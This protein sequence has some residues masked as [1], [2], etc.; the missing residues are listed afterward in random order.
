M[1]DN[2]IGE[3]VHEI[4]ATLEQVSGVTLPPLPPPAT[5][6]EIDNAEATLGFPLPRDLRNL[7]RATRGSKD[8]DGTAI[9]GYI[10][11]TDISYLVGTT[12]GLVEEV[13]EFQSMLEWTEGDFRGEIPQGSLICFATEP[14]EG[15]FVEATGPLA[16]RVI[17]YNMHP[18]SNYAWI[19]LGDNLERYCDWVLAAAKLGGITLA[20]SPA[21]RVSAETM[22]ADRSEDIPRLR[23]LLEPLK[24]SL[25][26]A[27]ATPGAFV[28][29]DPIIIAR[30]GFDDLF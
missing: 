30:Y 12:T 10:E 23:A 3:L 13:E 8:K 14:N 24:P 11:L 2:R 16:P 5:E 17:S 20:R 1:A 25:D 26:A 21:G 22:Q 7:Y 9:I 27:G 6:E 15:T 4:R 28:N 29:P 18:G 19:R